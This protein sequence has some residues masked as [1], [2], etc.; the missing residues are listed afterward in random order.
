GL[1]CGACKQQM[2]ID[3]AYRRQ[4]CNVNG[5]A[6]PDCVFWT[7]TCNDDGDTCWRECIGA[8]PP[9]ITT[10]QAH[11]SPSSIASFALATALT[12][13]NTSVCSV[14]TQPARGAV[15]PNEKLVAANTFIQPDQLLVYPIHFE[16]IGTI[17]ARDV[18]VTDP[19]D[20]NLDLSTLNVLTPQ[21]A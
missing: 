13:E 11:K 17:E 16:N 18:F 20:S 8:P 1:R 3:C 7:K 21:G 12:A 4:V 9:S 6:S 5:D 14:H 19:L 15:D 10:G 2:S